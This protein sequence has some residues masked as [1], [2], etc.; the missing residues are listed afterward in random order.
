[1]S[2]WKVIVSKAL[3]R[4]VSLARLLLLRGSLLWFVRKVE[5]LSSGASCRYRLLV[6][7]S[8][9]TH[10][11]S[12]ISFWFHFNVN[13]DGILVNTSLVYE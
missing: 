13:L 8:R 7:W 5:H 2:V 6:E 1:M 4:I 3:R 9:G 10:N 12:L 11:R